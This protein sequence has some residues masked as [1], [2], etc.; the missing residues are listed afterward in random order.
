[1]ARDHNLILFVELKGKTADQQM[2][3]DAVRIATERGVLDRC[4]F[5][6]LKYNPIKYLEETYPN[7]ETGYLAFASCG[8]TADIPCD[9]LALE[10]QVVRDLVIDTVRQSGKGVLVWTVNSSSEQESFLAMDA[11]AIITD[12]MTRAAEEKQKIANWDDGDRIRN[13]LGSVI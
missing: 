6:S 7:V 5:I 2:A 9:Y 1:M 3:D 11:D 10:E 13:V 4:V 12:N 8:D